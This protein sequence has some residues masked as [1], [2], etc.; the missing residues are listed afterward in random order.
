[1]EVWQNRKIF[2]WVDPSHAPPPNKKQHYPNYFLQEYNI[3]KANSL[4]ETVR[5]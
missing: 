1:M 2:W 5:Q 4:N 3:K